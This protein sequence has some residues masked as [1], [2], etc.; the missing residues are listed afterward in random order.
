MPLATTWLIATD[1][2]N[3]STNVLTLQ[4]GHHGSEVAEEEVQARDRRLRRVPVGMSPPASV[5]H[6]DDKL[7]RTSQYNHFSVPIFPLRHLPNTS[8]CLSM[9]L[10]EIFMLDESAN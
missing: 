7:V 6:V 5:E 8:P 9:L 3:A 1:S 2:R 4:V 10:L